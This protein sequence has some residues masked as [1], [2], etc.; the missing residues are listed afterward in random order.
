MWV[1]VTG[2]VVF[3]PPCNFDQTTQFRTTRVRL[4]GRARPPQA[5][6]GYLLPQPSALRGSSCYP[7]SLPKCGRH[8]LWRY[9]LCRALA[10]PSCGVNIVLAP[11]LLNFQV[12]NLLGSHGIIAFMLVYLLII[13]FS[14]NFVGREI[15]VV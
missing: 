3:P 5:E 15:E 13:C 11:Y 6:R 1:G 4:N 10:T 9:F 12:F 14:Y 7:V 8:A 2:E